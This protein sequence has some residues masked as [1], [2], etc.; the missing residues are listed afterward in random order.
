MRY[1]SSA[2]ALNRKGAPPKRW[3]PEELGPALLARDDFR[4]IVKNAKIDFW[5][6]IIHNAITNAD[7]FRIAGW[8]RTQSA[9]QPPPLQVGDEDFEAP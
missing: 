5:R 6:N 8:V 3:D 4:K 2:D 9:F 1:E 7:V